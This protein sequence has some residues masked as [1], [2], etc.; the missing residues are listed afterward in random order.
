MGHTFSV[1]EF[2]LD[3]VN[4]LSKRRNVVRPNFSEQSID[5]SAEAGE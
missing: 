4:L 1:V 3:L 5:F 2:T